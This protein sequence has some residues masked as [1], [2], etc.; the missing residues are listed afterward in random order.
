MKKAFA[1]LFVLLIPGLVVSNNYGRF[2]GL[3]V[4]YF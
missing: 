3:Y 2:G 4:M 1:V